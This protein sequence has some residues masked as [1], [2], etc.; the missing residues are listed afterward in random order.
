MTVALSNAL[1]S[2]HP[3]F[4]SLS[5]GGRQALQARC[6]LRGFT[7]GQELSKADLIP[8]EVLLLAEG[9]ARLLCRD[10]GRLCT[11]E[12][13]VSG[14]F[15]G[16]A[17]LLRAQACE[18][19]SAA[20]P[21]QAWVIPDA[22]MLELLG[23]EPSFASWC[24]GHLFTAELLA[25]VEQVL[26]AHPRQGMRALHEMQ[27]VRTAARLIQPTAEVLTQLH[28]D[29]VLLA[30]SHNLPFMVQILA[31]EQRVAWGGG[32]G[33]VEALAVSVNCR[34]P[35]QG[36]ERGLGRRDAY[37]KGLLLH[38]VGDE[39]EEVGMTF[40]EATSLVHNLRDVRPDQRVIIL[41]VRR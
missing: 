3:A 34:G 32:G 19:V 18:A 15:V 12:K 4:A 31:K 14:S 2:S 40:E 16:L 41:G 26:A 17:S 33:E 24:A 39:R 6:E 20:G 1:L 9:Q 27:R 8:S 5:E 23:S 11:V 10:G 36:A 25:L 28:P 29:V 7:T 13:L 22:L 30:A 21:L 38:E 35:A 37:E